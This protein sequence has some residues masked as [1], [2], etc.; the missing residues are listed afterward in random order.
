M[1]F[2]AVVAICVGIACIIGCLGGD[3][4]LRV[5]ALVA[6]NEKLA[7]EM[8]ALA[9][10]AKAGTATTGEI[11]DGVAKI[12]DQMKRNLDEIKAIKSEGNSTAAIIGG[13][14]GAVARTGLH[15]VATVIPASGPLGLGIQAILTL[16]LGGSSTAKKVEAPKAT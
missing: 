1:R 16:L 5:D 4:Q 7:L 6:E 13:I 15:A 14:V 10:K 8:K 3:S 2:L 11:A 12:Q 9:E